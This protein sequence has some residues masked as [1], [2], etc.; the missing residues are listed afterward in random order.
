METKFKDQYEMKI[1]SPFDSS[2]S[3]QIVD[4]ISVPEIVEAYKKEYATDTAYIFG[5]LK[6]IYLCRC[7]LTDL[8]F[9]YPRNLHGDDRFYASLSKG[10]WYY[11]PE[12]W[13][14]D[15]VIEYIK[16]NDA[17]LEIGSGSGAFIKML[18][19]SKKITYC[20]L[21]LNKDGIAKAKQDGV[22]LTNELLDKHVIENSGRYNVACSFQVFEHV[23][24]IKQLFEDSVR[25]LAKNGL[26]IISVPNNEVDFLR[27]NVLPSRYLNM[28]PHH[29][30][31]FTEDSFR[32]IAEIN[33]LEIVSILKENIQPMHVDVYLY[34][35]INRLFLNIS[36]F[37][38]IFWKL[39]LHTLCRGIVRRRASKILGHTILVVLKKR[40]A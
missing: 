35:M 9:F 14:Y 5:D 6:E 36:I 1:A 21:E 28:P 37:T 23:S 31:L 13:E 8:E 7:P 38:R 39:K 12:R 11:Q 20:G 24:D 15:K 19:R 32:K 3:S 4:T 22:N 18:T 27:N 26:L 29:V 34:N 2:V 25:S 17:V 10:D 33:D 16:D 40:S 30:N